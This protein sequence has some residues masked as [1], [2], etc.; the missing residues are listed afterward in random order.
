MQ[1]VNE[2]EI[3]RK[4]ARLGTGGMFSGSLFAHSIAVMSGRILGRLGE[5]FVHFY[6][7]LPF[8][9]SK[10]YYLLSFRSFWCR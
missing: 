3:V 8:S 10:S 2:T 7:N 6:H 4:F 9:V 1:G 5:I